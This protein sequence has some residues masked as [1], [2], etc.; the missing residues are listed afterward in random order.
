MAAAT[1]MEELT[2]VDDS[3]SGLEGS[4][5]GFFCGEKDVALAVVSA[6]HS[7]GDLVAYMDILS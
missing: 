4:L 3:F 1:S 5:D 2:D 7:G 6:D